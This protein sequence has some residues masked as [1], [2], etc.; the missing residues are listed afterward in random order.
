[1]RMN[2]RNGSSQ[3]TYFILTDING[4]LTNELK[5]KFN[6]TEGK[7][8][9]N[10]EPNR[11]KERKWQ[12]GSC[13]SP[14]NVCHSFKWIEIASNLSNFE[15]KAAA[16]MG[17]PVYVLHPKWRNMEMYVRVF[18]REK[19]I[20]PAFYD[21][22]WRPSYD[23]FQFLFRLDCRVYGTATITSSAKFW[24]DVLDAILID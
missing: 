24:Y 1:M 14:F 20:L 21:V 5:C 13:E 6:L 10:R 16:Q 9:K 12:K 19:R 8:I 4:K 2:W 7:N 3:I 23:E 15:V 22:S 18:A 11:T 17:L